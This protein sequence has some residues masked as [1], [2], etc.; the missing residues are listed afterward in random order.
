METYLPLERALVRQGT[1]LTPAL[2]ERLL[3][4]A[5]VTKYS[6]KRIERFMDRHGLNLEDTLDCLEINEEHG[7]PLHKIDYLLDQ[8]YSPSE[9]SEV[10][11][12]REEVE[13]QFLNLQRVI[14][15]DEY[16]F[17]PPRISDY[18]SYQNIIFLDGFA[19][20]HHDTDEIREYI[21]AVRERM[22][23]SCSDDLGVGFVVH[24]MREID[25]SQRLFGNSLGFDELLNRALCYLPSEFSNG[26]E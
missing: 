4:V 16:Q 12:L 2:R 21:S 3:G 6:E 19:G 23:E 9:I 17:I 20:W 7:I 22:K 14:I 15:G 26:E 13:P 1:E 18:I 8:G 5:S 24:R 11:E 25:E 10:M